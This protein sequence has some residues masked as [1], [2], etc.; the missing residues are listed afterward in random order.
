MLLSLAGVRTLERDTDLLYPKPLLGLIETILFLDKD[1]SLA[2]LP[3]R[4][5]L[6]M[7]ICPS[8]F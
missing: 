1:L 8:V 5:G 3:S 7:D 2:C 6:Y 4:T